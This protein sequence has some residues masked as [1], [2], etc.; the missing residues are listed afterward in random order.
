MKSVKK[1]LFSTILLLALMLPSVSSAAQ[2]S[3]EKNDIQN[4]VE[5]MQPGWNL[6][7]TFDAVGADETAWGNPKV[8][9]EFIKQIAD[10]GYKSIRIPVTFDQ[11]MEEVPNYTIDA[12][13]LNSLD[14]VIQW[15]LD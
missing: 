2:N 4:Y 8:T 6:G 1:L 14:Q 15:S 9:Q 11:R 5:A 10:Q 3:E 12:E 7:N 13:F